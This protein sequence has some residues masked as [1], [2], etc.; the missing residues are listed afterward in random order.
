LRL[1]VA[2]VWLWHWPAADSSI[3]RRSPRRCP[4]AGGAACCRGRCCARTTI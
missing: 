3:G 1:L 2:G 4:T